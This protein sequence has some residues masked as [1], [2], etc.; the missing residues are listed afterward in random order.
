[1]MSMTRTQSLWCGL[2]ALLGVMT[3]ASVPAVAQQQKPNILFNCMTA[4][5]LQP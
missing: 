3:V 5:G 2:L 4:A 1:M